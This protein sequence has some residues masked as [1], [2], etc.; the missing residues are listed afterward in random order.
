MPYGIYLSA[1]GAHAQS[2]RL[3]VLA[4][5]LANVDT[6]GF[7]RDQALF[8]ARLAEATGR[9]MDEPGSGSVN[10]LGGGVEVLGTITDYSQAAL[11][12]TERPTDFAINGDSFFVVQKGR[13][14]LLT[15]AGNFMLD[16]TGQLVTPEGYP[17]MSDLKEPIVVDTS[18]PWQATPDGA[19]AQAGDTFY[20][21]M[22]RP[23]S[24][25]DLAKVGENLFAPL[26]PV[27][28]VDPTQRQVVV[29]F[30]EGSNV[31]PTAE[32]VDLIETS[33]AFEAN[34]AMIR[35]Q[36]ELLNNLISQVLKE[37]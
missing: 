34:I 36:D 10:D 13:Q 27:T 9:G 18:I 2:L 6:V 7:K 8:Q 17:V 20:M 12:A 11:K 25:G 32:M 30:L 22:V 19:I 1:E 21:A 24:L 29:G 35:N 31:Q 26:A 28:P 3:D 15:R 33:R 4:N 37:T 23:R 5:N 14:Q 16:N